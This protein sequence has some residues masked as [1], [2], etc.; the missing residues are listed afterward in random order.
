MKCELTKSRLTGNVPLAN[1]SVACGSV[2]RWCAS[3]VL[4]QN[5]AKACR[6]YGQERTRRVRKAKARAARLS[7]SA[8]EWA[9]N[10]G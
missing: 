3:A 1:V 10:E 8:R 2:F 4:R 6:Q 7:Q 5:T 9:E